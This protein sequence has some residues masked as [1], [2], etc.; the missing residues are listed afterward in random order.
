MMDLLATLEK[1]GFPN[2]A[3]ELVLW[4]GMPS[5]LLVL[6]F[7]SFGSGASHLQPM[8]NGAAS[9]SGPQR[10]R[11]TWHDL[12]GLGKHSLLYHVQG[13]PPEGLVSSHQVLIPLFCWLLCLLLVDAL[14]PAG[15]PTG[16][17]STWSVT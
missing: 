11:R 2:F 4:D 5:S 3:K 13:Y 7:P 14:G 17:G 12:N 1:N 8:S 9:G 15:Q 16:R 10:R 6:T